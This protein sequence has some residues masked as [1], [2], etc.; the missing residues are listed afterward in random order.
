MSNS[1]NIFPELQSDFDLAANG[2]K[3]DNK[4]QPRSVPLTIRV[5][6]E[7]KDQ[8]KQAAGAIALSSYIRQKL[9]G[10]AEAFRPV[11][12]QKKQKEPAIDA[13][14]MA[15]LL[16]MFG[17]SELATSMLALSLAAAQGHIDISEEIEEKID[18]A[19]D[20]IH[21]IKLALIMALGVKPQSCGSG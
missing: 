10:D 20:D 19:C 7:E 16:G 17:Q 18:C 1:S 14:E 4:K 2:T 11:R 5:T 6:Q 13:V 9:F 3:P 15:R 8:I 21:T 12:Y